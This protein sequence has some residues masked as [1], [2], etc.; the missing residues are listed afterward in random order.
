MTNVLI[1]I[2]GED[3]D[4]EEVLFKG[5]KRFYPDVVVL[6][7]KSKYVKS[8]KRIEKNLR[9]H[10]IDI[11][12]YEISNFPSLE[13][14][15]MKIRDMQS[16]YDEDTIVI[17]VDCDYMTSCIA[18]SSAFVNGIAAIGILDDEI[19]AYPIMK[20]SY[21]NAVNDKKMGDFK[22]Y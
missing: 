4:C 19:I 6:L 17:N 2:V 11:N 8:A 3:K 18:L 22:T 7:V 10:D 20:F 15:F 16:L 5:F 13:E 14:V 21:Y 12:V 1:G 9:K